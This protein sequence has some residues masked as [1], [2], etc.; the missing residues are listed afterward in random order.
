MQRRMQKK[1]H[2]P[3]GTW[4]MERQKRVQNPKVHY[5][6]ENAEEDAEKNMSTLEHGEWRD[7][8]GCRKHPKVHYIMENGE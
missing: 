1:V 2:E 4:R 3:I 8:R 6:M 7:R 5:I